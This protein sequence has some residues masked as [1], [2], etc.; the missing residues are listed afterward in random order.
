MGRLYLCFTVWLVV[1]LSGVAVGVTLVSWRADEGYNPFTLYASVMEGRLHGGFI[2]QDVTVINDETNPDAFRQ[3][4][5][6]YPADG[7]FS[8]VRVIRVTEVNLYQVRF[9][10]NRN[11]LTIGDLAIRWGRPHRGIAYRGRM[12][13]QWPAR[14]VTAIVKVNE[15]FSYYLPVEEIIFTQKDRIVTLFPSSL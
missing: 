2:C 11:I 13:L 5:I 15:L 9:T 8:Q 14:G 6:A 1:T 12:S 7:V 4:C 3:M 10:P